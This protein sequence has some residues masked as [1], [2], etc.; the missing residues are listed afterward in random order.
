MIHHS[1]KVCDAFVAEENTLI[2][3]PSAYPSMR[4]RSIQ[5][6]SLSIF[7]MRWKTDGRYFC[8]YWLFWPICGSWFLYSS[9]FDLDL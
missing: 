7:G 3:A 5:N 2:T 6:D 9:Y 4:T 8:T 1:L